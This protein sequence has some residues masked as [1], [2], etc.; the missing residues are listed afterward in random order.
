MLEF[1]R[2]LLWRIE[3]RNQI[4]VQL[5]SFLFKN[6]YFYENFEIHVIPFCQT[7]ICTAYLIAISLFIYNEKSYT[8]LFKGFHFQL[9]TNNKRATKLRVL[10]I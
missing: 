3:I 10:I 8:I 4:I 5:W 6:F 1:Y 2:T 9:T 7:F